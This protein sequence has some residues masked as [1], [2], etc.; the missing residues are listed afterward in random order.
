MIG[1]ERAPRAEMEGIMG[2]ILAPVV[3]NKVDAWESFI[4]E[5]TG[6]RQA[7][8]DDFNR[9]YGLTRHE[10]WLCETPAGAFACAIHEGPGADTLV[11]RLA[12]STNGFDKWFAG[13]LLELHGMDV[14]RPPPGK[15]PERKLYWTA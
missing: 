11:P 6:P 8:L 5:V 4:N 7:E 2:L 12:Q 13:K 9:R 15:M 10:A 1:F 3:G 14:T